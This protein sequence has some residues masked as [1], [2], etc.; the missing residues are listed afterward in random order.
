LIARVAK[1]DPSLADD[2]QREVEVLGSR[3]PFG[4]NFERHVPE[5]IELPNRKVRLGDKVVFREEQDQGRH[6]WTV[7]GISGKGEMRVAK[8]LEEESSGERKTITASLGDLVV[9]AEF[10]DPIYPGLRSTG[11]VE[12]GTDKPFHT[13]IN[14]ENYHVIQALNFVCRGQVDCIYIDPPYN[15][16]AR[17]WKYNNDYV[18]AEDAYRHSKWLAMLERRLRLARE[19]LNPNDSVLIV[20]IDEKE[21]LRL[22]LLLEQIFVDARIQMVSVQINPAAVARAGYF[23]RADE[24]YFFVMIGEAGVQPMSLG[25]EW[26]TAKGRTH[27]GQIR[28][29]LLRKSGSSP[30]RDGHPETFYPLHAT[31]DCGSI[32]RVGEPIGE[33]TARKTIEPGPGETLLWPIRDDGSEGRWRVGPRMASELL[34]NGFLKVGRPKGERT[35]V[36]YLATGERKKIASGIYEVTGRAEDGSVITKDLE[37]VERVSVPGTQW[38]IGSHDST[39]YG[40]RL[41]RAFL[42]N[43]KFPFPKSLFAVEDALR[44]FVG[45]KPEALILD[46]FAGSGTTAHAVIRLNKQDGGQRRSIMVTN[47]EVSAEEAAE[48]R[49]QGLSPGDPEWE[50]LGICEHIT[51]PRI[52]AVITGETPEGEPIKGEYKFGDEFPIPE[53][54][55]E[56]AEFFDLTYEDPEQVRYGLGFDAIS[57]LLWMRAGATGPRV[58]DSDQPLA[59]ADTYAILFDLDHAAAFVAAVREEHSLRVVYIVSDDEARFQIIVAQLPPGLETVRLYAAYLESFK[60]QVGA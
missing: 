37:S 13:V 19:L 35:P 46:F 54:F 10:R 55:A 17:D 28:W 45:D 40:S 1:A 23:G 53:G 38:R 18:D 43:R 3:R 56:N 42:P 7:L 2:L 49:A 6:I 29:D 26:I 14:G 31:A 57:P 44:F 48:L 36:Y 12:Q 51:K 30:T 21:Y 24:Y 8:L 15:S 58:E 33:K 47:N 9:I 52:R 39:Q 50:K 22:G 4:L 20:T 32:L 34:A 25:A 5:S 60:V 41:L 11:A 27:R 59:F 16:G